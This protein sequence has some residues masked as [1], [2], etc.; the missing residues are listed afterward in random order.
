MAPP[1]SPAAPVTGA[2]V[3]PRRWLLQWNEDPVE[4]FGIFAG[5]L[6]DALTAAESEWDADRGDIHAQEW[7]ADDDRA[8]RN[9]ARRER[10]AQRREAGDF[11][12]PLAPE[13]AAALAAIPM[14][15][16]LSLSDAATGRPRC[17]TCGQWRRWR[18]FVGAR[19]ATAF[20]GGVVDFAP[21]CAGCRS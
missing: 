2:R 15:A 8:A 21:S 12:R 3:K 4:T 7:T 5:S 20:A 6:D 10:Y 17:P 14:T 1:E 18:D 19:S 13:D 16:W 11:D 9:A